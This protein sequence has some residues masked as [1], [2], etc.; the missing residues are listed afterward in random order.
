MRNETNQISFV[1]A[2][3][4]S[5]LLSVKVGTV[6][7]WARAGIIPSLRFSRRV[8]RFDPAEVSQALRERAAQPS[9][10]ADSSEHAHA[11]G[12]AGNES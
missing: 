5:D 10:V 11:D 7:A 8:I 12:R 1:T 2:G 6:L 3:E 9:S 4:L